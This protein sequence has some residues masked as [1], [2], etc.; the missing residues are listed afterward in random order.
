MWER[1]QKLLDRLESRLALWAA[2]GGSSVVGAISL[3]I[4]SATEWLEPYAPASYWF[5][6]LI[7]GVLSFLMFWLAA[8][9]RNAW[10]RARAFRRWRD[11][12]HLVNPLD[13]E[14]TRKR[15]RIDDFADPVRRDIENKRFVECQLLGPSVLFLEKNCTLTGVGFINCDLVVLPNNKKVLIQNAIAVRDIAMIDG[16]ISNCVLIIR[17]D[18]YDMFKKNG[19][20]FIS[21]TP[22]ELS[23][24]Q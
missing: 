13:R 22:D 1:F 10:L 11:V 24:T 18:L 19:A 6:A 15:I 2:I 12:E 23:H 9:V 8:L 17:P 16:A 5:A 14:F 7:G 3:W 21:I 4:A 20:N